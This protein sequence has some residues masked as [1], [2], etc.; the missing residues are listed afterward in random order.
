VLT[1]LG[2]ALPG[3]AVVKGIEVK[4]ALEGGLFFIW[5]VQPVRAGALVG[6]S[7][8]LGAGSTG[9]PA[10]LWGTAW[11]GAQI[12]EVGF[13]VAIWVEDLSAKGA[14]YLLR[15]PVV[16]VYW[17]FAGV[18]YQEDAVLY[19]ERLAQAR[20]DGSWRE[21]TTTTAYAPISEATGDLFRLPPS[22]LEGR[23]AELFVKNSQGLLVPAAG[24]PGKDKLQAQV[25]Y[26]PCYLGR[27]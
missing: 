27:I 9:G 18:S 14:L 7:G 4:A 3:A 25:F 16:T 10:D 22:G 8:N 1:K 20:F 26:R 11:T 17:A 23:A 21:D 19:S 2:F 15:S 12:N 5:R 24:D 6:F 13:G